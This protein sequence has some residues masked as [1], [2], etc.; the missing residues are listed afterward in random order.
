MTTVANPPLFYR[1]VRPVD[2]DGDRTLGLVVPERPFSFAAETHVLP[3]VAAEFPAA[4]R[5]YPIVFAGGTPAPAAVLLVGLTAG[6]C[7]FIDKAGRW[8]GTYVPA[9]LRRYPFILGE[10]PSADPILCIELS[11][12]WAKPGAGERLFKDDGSMAPPLE[13]ALRISSDYADAAKRTEAFTR[14]L[15]DLGL[16]R[17]ITIEART[18]DGRQFTLGGFFAVDEARYRALPDETFLELRRDGAIQAIEAH[19]FSLGAIS[20]VAEKTVP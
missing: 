7:S 2:R 5:E 18:G 8:T 13:N 20:H 15:A 11:N 3:T 1:D 4:A 6:R 10:V 16:Y 9:Y 14:K 17:E 19:L 12:G